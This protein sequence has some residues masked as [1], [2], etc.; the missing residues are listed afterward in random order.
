M[1]DPLNATIAKV[2]QAKQEIAEACLNGVDTW[3]KYLK[4]VG[5]AQGLQEALDII[6]GVLKEDE[7]DY[8]N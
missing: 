8:G 2:K 3:D 4:L 6:D 1:L 5:K 7:E